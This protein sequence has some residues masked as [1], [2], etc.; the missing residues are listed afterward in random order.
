MLR[1]NTCSQ[2]CDVLLLTYH[3]GCTWSP[4]RFS[5][6]RYGLHKKLELPEQ[7]S[8][9]RESKSVQGKA[10]ICA[11]VS[12]SLTIMQSEVTVFKVA[13]FFFY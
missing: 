11:S 13:V 2:K 7:A 9:L 1:T 5:C 6:V 3:M 10:T 4:T 12:A 8:S